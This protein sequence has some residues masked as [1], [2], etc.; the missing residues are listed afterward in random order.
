MACYACVYLRYMRD[1]SLVLALVAWATVSLG[2]FLGSLLLVHLKSQVGGVSGG[3]GDGGEEEG[4]L[5]PAV[6]RAVVRKGLRYFRWLLLAQTCWLAVC[7]GRPQAA[8]GAHPVVM[9]LIGELDGPGRSP[10]GVWA[11]DAAVTLLQLALLQRQLQP[12]LRS[13]RLSVPQLSTHRYGILAPLR[14]EAWDAGDELE[15]LISLRLA[16]GNEYGS[17]SSSSLAPLEQ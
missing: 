16:P 7:H 11:L 10:W 14:L 5:E 15:L 17:I 3:G 6:V 1:G 9:P 4:V 2:E 13:H 8:R 12:Q